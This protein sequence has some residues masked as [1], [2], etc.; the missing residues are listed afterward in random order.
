MSQMTTDVTNGTSDSY[1][2]LITLTSLSFVAFSFLSFSSCSFSCC[3]S[4]SN[5]I[6]FYKH[7]TT[8]LNIYAITYKSMKLML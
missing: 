1:I 4:H 7:T 6:A 3:R 8:L 2:N 5:F